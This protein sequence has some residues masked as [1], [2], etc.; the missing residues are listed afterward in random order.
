MKPRTA[1]LDGVHATHAEAAGECAARGLRLCSRAELQQCCKMGCGLDKHPT[2]WTSE[3]CSRRECTER[4]TAHEGA[5]CAGRWSRANVS[6]VADAAGALAV[7]EQD[8]SGL[9]PF[10]VP[11]FWSETQGY[12]TAALPSAAAAA[13][14]AQPS[15][16]R[17]APGGAG[18]HA[19]LVSGT[20]HISLFHSLFHMVPALEWYAE[21]YGAQAHTP[22]RSH[23]QKD[24]DDK[25]EEDEQKEKNERLERRGRSHGQHARGVL[26]HVLPLITNRR[27]RP[28]SLLAEPFFNLSMISLGARGLTAQAKGLFQQPGRCLRFASVTGGHCPFSFYA[29]DAPA[30]LARFRA[31]VAR[32]LQLSPSPSAVRRRL[33]LVSRS[34]AGGGW[35]KGR[36]DPGPPRQII[37][38]ALLGDTAAPFQTALRNLG[39]T[40]Q[41][42]DFARL[43]VAEQFGIVTS[44][45]VL[46]GNHGQGMAWAAML[47]TDFARCGV[48]EMLA[49]GAAE[50]P[51]SDYRDWSAANG[52]TYVPLLQA[53][54]PSC[55]GRPI[56]TCGH[57][58]VDV[59]ELTHAASMLIRDLD[60]ADP[61]PIPATA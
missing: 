11:R 38:E 54:T 15:S 47:P 39:Y 26:M 6:L 13:A 33:L 35:S 44:S 41:L 29:R 14:Q 48:I 42:V 16:C 59:S 12:T 30:R 34:E 21:R 58:V 10:E 1:L 31:A 46:L 17:A 45:R 18:S 55:R 22:K 19:F 32:T 4:C 3:P 37:N 24:D 53:T 25:E 20:H 51:P 9:R 43:P 49:R 8:G 28:P 5:Q 60:A 36:G 40:V 23:T 2:I 27:G 61:L 52:A 56:R 57:V 50:A 7:L